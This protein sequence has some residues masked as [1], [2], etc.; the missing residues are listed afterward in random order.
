MLT[1]LLPFRRRST[2]VLHVAIPAI[3]NMSQHLRVRAKEEL[4]QSRKILEM[5]IS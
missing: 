4:R 3:L 2:P 5:T 1:N